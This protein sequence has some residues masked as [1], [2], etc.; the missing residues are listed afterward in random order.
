MLVKE[1]A[2]ITNLPAFKTFKQSLA[3][4]PD[5]KMLI[6]NIVEAEMT[7]TTTGK[8][9]LYIIRDESMKEIT[10]YVDELVRN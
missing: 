8:E 9:H 1:G 6:I 2:L 10:R 7:L 5:Q 4:N 3:D